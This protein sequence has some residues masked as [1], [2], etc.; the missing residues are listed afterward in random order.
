MLVTGNNLIQTQ[1]AGSAGLHSLGMALTRGALTGLTLLLFC[2]I[3]ALLLLRQVL[4]AEQ[5]FEDSLFWAECEEEEEEH[6]AL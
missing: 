6:S 1:P 2:C 5:M 4:P 3:A